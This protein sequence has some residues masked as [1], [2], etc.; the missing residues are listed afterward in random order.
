MSRN[1]AA[2]EKLEGEIIMIKEQIKDIN[3]RLSVIV[4]ILEMSQSVNPG[5]DP[6]GTGGGTG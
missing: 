3:E 6:V 5:D 1:G 2:I 4:E